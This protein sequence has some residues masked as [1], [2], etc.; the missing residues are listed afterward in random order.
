MP[1]SLRRVKAPSLPT[2]KP[3]IV[4]LPVFV[5]YANRPLPVTA[6][7]HAAVCSVGTEGLTTRS[8][9]VWESRRYDETS[10]AVAAPPKASETIRKPPLSKAKPKGV[11]PEEG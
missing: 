3:V 7:Q 6:I 10:L 9:P 11:I 1:L 4:P 2:E 5:V 8:I